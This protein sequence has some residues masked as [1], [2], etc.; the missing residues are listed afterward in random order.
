M[1]IH[2]GLIDMLVSAS[3]TYR[4]LLNIRCGTPRAHDQ[5]L[6]HLSD[7]P[8]FRDSAP[9]L[10][11]GLHLDGRSRNMQCVAFLLTALIWKV[12]SHDGS[13]RDN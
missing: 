2:Q 9:L 11:V 3:G 12:C 6:V 7:W 13:E 10:G 4:S 8:R 5:R 1:G